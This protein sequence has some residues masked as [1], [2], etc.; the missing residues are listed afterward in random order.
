MT[1]VIHLDPLGSTRQ[2]LYLSECQLLVSD[3]G[4]VN[5]MWHCDAWLT[6][7]KTNVKA[8]GYT[9][10]F[11][12]ICMSTGLEKKLSTCLDTQD[13]SIEHVCK[14]SNYGRYL[15]HVELS[16]V[17]S[18]AF[19]V[20]AYEPCVVAS[21]DCPGNPFLGREFWLPVGRHHPDPVPRLLPFICLWAHCRGLHL[22]CW[23]QANAAD[24]DSIHCC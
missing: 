10:T 14:Q 3:P 1:L 13:D 7:D 8:G 11:T 20:Q 16:D 17:V 18:R 5:Q 2:G 6:G 22:F 12:D 19:W 21:G 24:F 15:Q 9:F 4:A 23:L